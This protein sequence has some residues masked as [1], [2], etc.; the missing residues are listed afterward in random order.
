MC[1]NDIVVQ[2]AEPLFFLDYFA[3]R[4]ARR[5]CGRGRGRRH[6]A[7]L[8]G[9]GCALIGG[10]TAEMPGL[11][12]KGDFDLAGFASAPSSAVALLPRPATWRGR[13]LIGASLLGV[14]SNGYSLV[15]RVVS[16]DGAACDR[17]APFASAATLGEALLRAD[18]SLIRSGLAAIRAGGV[19]GLAHITGGGI[20]ENLPRALP[21]RPR[22][23]DRPCRVGAAPVFRLAFAPGRHRRTR[24]AAHLQLRHRAQSPSSRPE[25]ADKRLRNSTPMAKRQGASAR[26]SPVTARCAI[27]AS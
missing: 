10:E 8:Q 15:R 20:T 19:K 14:H 25:V 13:R 1:V 12:A 21:R 7:R 4:Q 6:R 22:C 17:P 2:G 26:S 5:G 18:A 27:W 24:D 3:T 9:S 16:D 23:R 11:Y